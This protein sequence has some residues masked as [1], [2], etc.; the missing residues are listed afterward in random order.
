LK[1]LIESI[2]AIVPDKYGDRQITVEQW[3]QMQDFTDVYSH[4]QVKNALAWFNEFGNV[5]S[6]SS[7]NLQQF[8]DFV[9]AM[10]QHRKKEYLDACI[11][12][13]TVIEGERPRI[14]LTKEAA[15]K[16]PVYITDFQRLPILTLSLEQSIMLVKNFSSLCTA[17]C[18]LF[19]CQ[20]LLSDEVIDCGLKGMPAVVKQVIRSIVA[21]MPQKHNGTIRVPFELWKKINSLSPEY[22]DVISFFLPKI[23]IVA[24]SMDIFM[25]SASVQSE[26]KKLLVEDRRKFYNGVELIVDQRDRELLKLGKKYCAQ[27]SKLTLT[28]A[29]AAVLYGISPALTLEFC[30]YFNCELGISNSF[31]DQVTSMHVEERK[32]SHDDEKD[33]QGS[34]VGHKRRM[35]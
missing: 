7:A 13:I 34:G 26:F 10:Y 22:Q 24:Y 23:N 30:C 4:Y 28:H 21:I 18:N 20:L 32:A 17:F 11:K 27:L 35:E 6:L 2:E 31:I 14:K 9:C 8:H 12:G 33:K 16:H 5:C 25:D 1:Q 29:Q 3:R 19:N 15:Q